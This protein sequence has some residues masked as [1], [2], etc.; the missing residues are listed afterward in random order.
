MDF[1]KKIKSKLK[2]GKKV[3]ALI[4]CK[5]KTYTR[6]LRLSKTQYSSD[7]YDVVATRPKYKNYHLK[8]SDIISLE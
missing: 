2:S 6:V 7:G 4:S 8:N 1:I 5:G 3:K